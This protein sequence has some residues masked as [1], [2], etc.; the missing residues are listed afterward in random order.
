MKN[1]AK[2]PGKLLAGLCLILFFCLMPVRSY[3]AEQQLSEITKLYV[4]GI[5]GSETLPQQKV[6]WQYADK[7]YYL[8]MPSGADLSNVQLHFTENSDGNENADSYVMIDGQKINCGDSANLSGTSKLQISLAGGKSVTV[9]IVKSAEI[10]A[11]FIQTA[12]GTLDKVHAS[13][14]N[15]EKGTMTTIFNQYEKEVLYPSC[16]HKYR[17]LFFRKFFTCFYGVI[18]SIPENGTNIQRLNKIY[19]IKVCGNR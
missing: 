18:K 6:N 10:P 11:M 13:K 2:T 15:K 12:S 7:G 14:D 9:N 17:P 19:T 1:A 5:Y 16:F 8:C 4:T 3:A